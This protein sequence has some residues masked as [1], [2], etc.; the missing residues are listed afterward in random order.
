MENDVSSV[1]DGMKLRANRKV[2]EGRCTICGGGFSLGEEVY[3]CP[4]CN[5]YHHTVCIDSG[6]RCPQAGAQLRREAPAVPVADNAPPPSRA[7]PPPQAAALQPPPLPLTP[8]QLQRRQI[9]AETYKQWSTESLERAYGVDKEKYDP[10]AL[11]IMAEEL[12]N[13][14]L[15]EQWM[16]PVCGTLNPPG[17]VCTN[18]ANHA[19]SVAPAAAAAAAPEVLG[20]P[21]GPDEK[22]CP[23]CAE[24]IKRD[25]VKCRF[26]GQQ[27][28]ADP[29]LAHIFGQGDS[30]P[31][32]IAK[33]IDSAASTALW[34]SIVGLFICAPILCPIAISNGN[35]AQKLLD[36]Y[37]DY[38]GRTS[39]GGK[40]RAGQV[41]GWIGIIGFVIA[42]IVRF[43]NS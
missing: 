26:C 2:V 20:P 36:Q 30:V 23:A 5:G 19:A 32:D 41:I 24:V 35:T 21:L 27:L 1:Y 10:M 3:S 8:E 15:T 33:R 6:S 29:A 12:K 16:C 4:A 17:A 31:S 28:T 39:A 25:A 38:R 11:D 14:R 22:R 37:P 42:M 43:S 13:R 40:S 18:E 34:T 9:I 7:A